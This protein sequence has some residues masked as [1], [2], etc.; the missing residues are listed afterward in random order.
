MRA[1]ILALL[2][3]PALLLNPSAHAVSLNEFSARVGDVR[4]SGALNQ[5]L[6]QEVTVVAA[7]DIFEGSLR[8]ED[9]RLPPALEYQELRRL[10]AYYQTLMHGS[11][12][13]ILAFWHPEERAQKAA[14]V[15][16]P[17][18]LAATRKYYTTNPSLEIVGMLYQNGSTSVLMTMGSH[19]IGATLKPYQG[20]LYL[21]DQP[22]DDVQLAVVEAS[23]RR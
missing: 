10:V 11:A 20:Q 9:V 6:D 8:I 3:G 13:D 2:L 22:A 17:Q 15:T 14:S 4:L 16:D 5:P 1:I 7:A 18:K 23:L 12:D 19:V 21:S